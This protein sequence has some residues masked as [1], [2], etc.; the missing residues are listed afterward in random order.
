[1]DAPPKRSPIVRQ[2]D[3]LA[4]LGARDLELF[5]AECTRQQFRRRTKLYTEGTVHKAT[6]IIESGLIRTF[7][8]SPAGKEITLGYWT[9]GDMIG[10]PFFFD[11]T[12]IHVWSAE[13]VEDSTV[14]AIS[15]RRLSDLMM[16]STGFASAILDAIA[17]KLMWDSLLLQSLATQSVPSRLAGMLV[18]LSTLYGE[19][20]PDGVVLG[21]GFTQEKLANMVGTTREWLNAQLK[22]LQQEGLLDVRGRKIVIRDL[23]RL[24]QST[25]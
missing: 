8:E 19:A 15:G 14:L 21:R 5:L 22:H 12:G 11:D 4:N 16:K 6:Y 3:I 23:A 13:A 24:E 1:M 20:T 9:T 10:G 25:P 18:R 7:Y 17:F 2:R